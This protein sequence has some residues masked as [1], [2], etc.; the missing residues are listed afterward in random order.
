MQVILIDAT[1]LNFDDIEHLRAKEGDKYKVIEVLSNTYVAKNLRTNNI[2]EL[3]KDRFE[4][5]K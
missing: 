4:L 2:D 5:C 3:N 1:M